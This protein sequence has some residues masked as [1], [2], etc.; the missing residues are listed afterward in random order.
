[1][2]TGM[3]HRVAAETEG[4]AGFPMQD[5]IPGR[6]DYDQ[7]QTLNQLSNPGPPY[8]QSFKI[9]ATGGTWVA[10]WVKL[11]PSAQVMISRRWDQA[12]HQALRSVGSLLLPLSA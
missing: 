2:S 6:W 4:E 10:Q 1:M 3:W 7:R 12:P 9:I 11:L 8:T 5:L